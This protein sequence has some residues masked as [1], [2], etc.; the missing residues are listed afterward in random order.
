MFD[1]SLDNKYFDKQT[2]IYL[3]STLR[4]AASVSLVLLISLASASACSLE[5]YN[6]GCHVISS[7]SVGRRLGAYL[8]EK[9]LD[10]WT[11]IMWL[12]FRFF[13][14]VIQLLHA[15]FVWDAVPDAVACH[16][17]EIVCWVAHSHWNVRECSH[18]LLFRWKTIL[19]LELVITKSAT[20][21][22]FSVNSVHH[23]AVPCRL[24]PFGLS[25]II[26]FVI[27]AEGYCSIAGLR[28]NG[29]A[30]TW[31]SAIYF[32]VSDKHD[33]CRA[34]SVNS[35][36]L[37]FELLIKTH[38]C[39]LKSRLV[40]A[41]L[42]ISVFY[43][44]FLEILFRILCHFFAAVSVED[45]KD[46]AITALNINR[47]A[48]VCVF[49]ATAPSLHSAGTPVEIIVL[50]W[51]WILVFNWWIEEPSHCMPIYLIN[52]SLVVCCWLFLL[53]VLTKEW[54]ILSAFEI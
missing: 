41:L 46:H 4:F 17:H 20:E 49:H 15:Q 16:K 1:D 31:I 42:K 35:H 8:V 9:F 27:F 19:V 26:W 54:L 44:F 32:G 3:W 38:K 18:S 36:R 52:L 24:D 47:F 12:R 40:F 43:E 5:L 14:V 51:L 45:T 53:T 22:E 34:A 39:L 48:N 33:T 2:L 10:R 7:Y 25:Q 28:N 50:S 13:D 11:H 37:T 21:G 30:V 29:P 6:D 23:N